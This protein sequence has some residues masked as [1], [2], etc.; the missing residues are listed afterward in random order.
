MLYSAPRLPY[1]DATDILARWE[2]SELDLSIINTESQEF[3]NASKN[4][5]GRPR[6]SASVIETF[7]EQ[8]VIAFPNSSVLYNRN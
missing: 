5:E 3:V 4:L 1:L 7:L 6:T 2:E 8:S